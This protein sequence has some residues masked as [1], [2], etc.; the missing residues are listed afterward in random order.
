MARIARP[1]RSLRPSELTAYMARGRVSSA[2][3]LFGL[4]L[5]VAWLRAGRTF[6]DRQRVM[7]LLIGAFL[8]TLSANYAPEFVTML[9]VA[10][11][12]VIA[13]DAQASIVDALRRLQA[14][15]GVTGNGT[16]TTRTRTT[17]GGAQP[18]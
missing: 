10:L 3:L 18:I 2:L 5:L 11:F 17:V 8:V 7:G 15:L 14:M 9:M 16:P 13:L 1:P 6:P 4:V 12:V